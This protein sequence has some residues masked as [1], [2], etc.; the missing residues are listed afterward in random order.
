MLGFNPMCSIGLNGHSSNLDKIVAK[1][2]KEN[3]YLVLNDNGE[4][5]KYVVPEVWEPQTDSG[6]FQA[7]PINNLYH[8]F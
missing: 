8:P 3:L 7:R 1:L 6:H 4:I 2:R 5:K